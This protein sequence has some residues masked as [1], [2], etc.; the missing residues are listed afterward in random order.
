MNMKNNIMNIYKLILNL[1]KVS[2]FI[3]SEKFHFI[4]VQRK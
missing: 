4:S 2:F 3:K 1:V